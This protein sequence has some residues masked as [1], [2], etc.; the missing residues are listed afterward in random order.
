MKRVMSISL[1]LLALAALGCGKGSKDTGPVLAS[2]GSEKI[3]SKDF[4]E[5]VERVAPDA[6][7]AKKLLEDPDPTYRGQ[8]NRMLG[9]LT[10]ASAVIQMAK[11]QNLDS[12]PRVRAAV[13]LALANAYQTAMLS[14][15][16]PAN[17]EPSED[18][19]KA[20][21]DRYAAQAKA[22]GQ[23]MPPYD[24][25]KPQLADAWRRDEQE[26]VMKQLKEEIAKRVPSTYADGYA[27][28]ALEGL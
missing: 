23:A 24:Q 27:P 3:T 22:A 15:R 1:G 28:V 10:D 18:Q 14:N 7:A 9:Q 4:R 2:V 26:R 21:Y 20:V 17:A 12:D 16:M 19:L 6:A 8:R 11:Q 13:K 5:L 25:V